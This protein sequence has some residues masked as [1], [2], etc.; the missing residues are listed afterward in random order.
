MTVTTAY[1]VN[2]PSVTMPERVNREAFAIVFPNTLSRM[3]RKD[4]ESPAMIPCD[5][6]R[7][8]GVLL[9][10]FLVDFFCG[11][12]IVMFVL[13]LFV[14]VIGGRDRARW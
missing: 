10:V 12:T 8:E 3:F 6:D 5:E 11:L 13:I 1:H 4:A 9:L 7:V 14:V 2:D